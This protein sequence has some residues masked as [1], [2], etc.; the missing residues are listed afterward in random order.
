M[1]V[2][3]NPRRLPSVTGRRSPPLG[4][5]KSN[6]CRMAAPTG[7]VAM[8]RVEDRNAIFAANYCLPVEGERLRPDP[9][10]R[11]GDRRIPACPVIAAACEQPHSLEEYDPATDLW[12]RRAPIMWRRSVS[13]ESSTPSAD[14]SS[15]TFRR[16]PTCRF[17]DPS[18]DRWTATHAASYAKRNSP[19]I[20]S[21]CRFTPIRSLDAGRSAFQASHSGGRVRS[22]PSAIFSWHTHRR[23]RAKSTSYCLHSRC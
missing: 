23:R 10:R 17:I 14:S 6:A 1:R 2:E 22:D 4:S 9:T 7:A 20:I 12:R 8:Q 21:H 3:L 11:A 18:S 16:F 13:A 19:M 15:K 5:N